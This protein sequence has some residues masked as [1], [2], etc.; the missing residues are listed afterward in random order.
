MW[1]KNKVY[2]YSEEYIL[3]HG[4]PEDNRIMIESHEDEILTVDEINKMFPC[5][6]V[7]LTNVNWVNKEVDPFSF[8]SATVAFYHCDSN[9]ALL[10]KLDGVVER[11]YVNAPNWMR[12]YRYDYK[13]VLK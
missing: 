8:T 1:D 7:A 4:E 2:G 10:L 6:V 9:K 12:G 13:P 11:V 3:E 5:Q